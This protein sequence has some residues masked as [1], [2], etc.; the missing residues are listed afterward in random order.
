MNRTTQNQFTSGTV[1]PAE[2]WARLAR[3]AGL[4]GETDLASE[5][6][7]GLADDARG[8]VMRAGPLEDTS[9]AGGVAGA[10]GGI[11]EDR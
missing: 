4:P 7:G 5:A 8:S 11:C 3:D 10:M 6:M 1:D 9:D 2:L